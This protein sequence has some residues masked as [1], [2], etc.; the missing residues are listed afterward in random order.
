MHID[1]NPI[2]KKVE[3]E[4]DVLLSVAFDNGSVSLLDL[5]ML[6]GGGGGGGG[7]RIVSSSAVKAH[8]TRVNALA[9]SPCA[10]SSSPPLLASGG[11]DGQVVLTP[12]G[13]EED[14]KGRRATLASKGGKQEGSGIPIAAHI[15]HTDYVRGLGWL[16]TAGAGGQGEG[17]VAAAAASP[18][19]SLPRPGVL[20]SG[21][22]DG[23]L[24]GWAWGQEGQ[25][26]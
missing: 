15:Q 24:K 25:M 19:S 10:S 18:L 17:T 11:D 23:R 5:R 13:F 26:T 2:E 6:R 3:N 4:N 1:E 21:G 20:L 14:G 12:L 7:G 9:F 16:A 8:K 22:W